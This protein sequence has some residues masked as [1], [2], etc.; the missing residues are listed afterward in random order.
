VTNQPYTVFGYKGKQVR[1]NIYSR[2]LVNAFWHFS[3]APRAGEV[4]NIG[5]GPTSNCSMLEAIAIVERLAGR[6]MQW[7]YTDTNRAGDHIWYVSDIRK[8]RTHYPEWELTRTLDRLIEEI[9]HEMSDRLSRTAS[10]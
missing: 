2:D 1:D 7:S 9:H 4:Y 5:G 6:P 3:Q 8:F 10:T